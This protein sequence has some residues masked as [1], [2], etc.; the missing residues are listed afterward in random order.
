MAKM[1]V[2]FTSKEHQDTQDLVATLRLIRP[3][4]NLLKA[5]TRQYLKEFGRKPRRT[6]AG[7]G[8]T[9]SRNETE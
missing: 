6:S 1:K 5:A 9:V 2:G 4:K 7:K 8:K 3:T